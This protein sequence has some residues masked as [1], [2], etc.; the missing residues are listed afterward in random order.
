MTSG[1]RGHSGRT[2]C[3]AAGLGE[4][5]AVGQKRDPRHG[6]PEHTPILAR[7]VLQGGGDPEPWD[8]S[9]CP[10]LPSRIWTQR[11]TSIYAVS[12][13]ASLMCGNQSRGGLERCFDSVTNHNSLGQPGKERTSCL[14]VSIIQKTRVT[15]VSCWWHA[16]R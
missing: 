9:A 12:L 5:L 11:L 8:P 15:I 4:G 2:F 6:D 16:S 3:V 13:F 7:L 10:R 14:Q 1:N